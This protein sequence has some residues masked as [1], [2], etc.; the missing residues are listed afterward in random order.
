M[1]C[2]RRSLVVGGG[3][4]SFDT[5]E[6]YTATLVSRLWSHQGYLIVTSPKQSPQS[7]ELPLYGCV[8]PPLLWRAAGRFS[9]LGLIRF[10]LLLGHLYNSIFRF[11]QLSSFL[12]GPL[13]PPSHLHAFDA[14]HSSSSI[15]GSIHCGPSLL[16]HPVLII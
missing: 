4:S 9:R 16:G 11:V 15:V 12:S 13:L 3:L 14:T 1:L 7:V 2:A 6:L 8:P 10:K 5:L